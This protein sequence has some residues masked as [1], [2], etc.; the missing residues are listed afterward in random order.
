MDDLPYFREK[1]IDHIETMQ[2]YIESEFGIPAERFK[3]FL[4]TRLFDIGTQ[5]EK[6]FTATTGTIFVI[7]MQPVY[8]FLILYYRTKFAYF[9]P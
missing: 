1:T 7:F 3:N 6:I 4:I 2:Q 9:Y 5:S 8:V